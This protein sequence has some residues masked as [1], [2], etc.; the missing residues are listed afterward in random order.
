MK[1][2]G[3]ACREREACAAEHAAVLVPCVALHASR[4]A[5]AHAAVQDMINLTVFSFRDAVVA[6][7]ASICACLGLVPCVA[8][9]ASR[10]APAHAQC[11]I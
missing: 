10:E 8:L 11:K 4:E 6:A 9:H 7:C 1:I 5:P 2:G 3:C